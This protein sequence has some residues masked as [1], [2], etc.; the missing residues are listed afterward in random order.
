MPNR[1]AIARAALRREAYKFVLKYQP[2]LPV[3]AEFGDEASWYEALLRVRPIRGDDL[4]PAEF[5][6]EDAPENVALLAAIDFWVLHQVSGLLYRR[7]EKFSI[8]FSRYLL[9]DTRVELRLQDLINGHGDRLSLEVSEAYEWSI[10]EKEKLATLSLYARLSLDDVGVG[11]LE[12]LQSLPLSGFKI[13][14]S[15]ILPLL[16]N[17]K[18]RDI[19]RM[20]LKMSVDLGLTVVAEFVA[21][22]KIWDWLRAEASKIDGL[23]LFVQGHAVA[24]YQEF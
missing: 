20:L 11:R 17:S 2:I 12:Y 18:D 4:R 16:E 22:A 7:D 5:M 3:N 6:P 13:D 19:V 23:R 14:G 8:N 24:E 15:L 21:T 10:Y 9:S 1:D